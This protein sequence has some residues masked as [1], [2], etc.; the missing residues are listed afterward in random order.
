MPDY[1]KGVIYKIYCKDPNID[2][3]YIGSTTDFNNRRY[4]HKYDCKTENR[5]KYN[6]KKY[7]FIREN[8]GWEQW[9][10]EILHYYSCS[11]RTELD[12]EEERNRQLYNNINE[13]RSYVT[14]EERR[15]DSVQRY[16]DNKEKLN[17]YSRQ[18]HID[19]KEKAKETVI[20]ECGTIVVKRSMSQHLKTKKHISKL[21]NQI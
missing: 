8:G 7:K 12:M 20:C 1:S 14:E 21:Q 11:N 5:K 15:E 16:I 3:V 2:K 4:N 10:M 13:K 9:N 17:K 19:N 6:Q 18:Y